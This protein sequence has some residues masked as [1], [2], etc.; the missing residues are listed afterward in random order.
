[1]RTR[2]MLQSG[3]L[4]MPFESGAAKAAVANSALAPAAREIANFF[5]VFSG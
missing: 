1:M 5:I 2:S 4:V 3:K